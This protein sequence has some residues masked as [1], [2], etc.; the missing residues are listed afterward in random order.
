M[1]KIWKIYDFSLPF[2][3]VA[4]VFATI[5]LLE[6]RNLGIIAF[7]FIGLALTGKFIYYKQK[8][9]K[10]LS[11]IEAVSA[12]LDFDQGKAF[13]ALTVPCCVIEE[14]GSFIWFN[15]SF[16][17]YFNI[18]A[19]STMK[20]IGEIVNRDSIEKLLIG[21]GYRVRVDNQYFAVY[22]NEIPVLD[23]KAYLLYFFD[24]TKLRIT[25]KEYNDSRPSIMLCVI[26]N[27]DEIYLKK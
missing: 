11:Q 19:D 27:A 9:D 3:F 22:S 16:R 12:E 7:V 5:I 26:D 20:S 10:L 24:E 8:K 13:Q 4:A 14:D 1:K 25:E 15:G 18:T 17:E 23:E 6:D 2:A 21:K